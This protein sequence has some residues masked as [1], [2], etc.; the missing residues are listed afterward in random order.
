MSYDNLFWGGKNRAGVNVPSHTQW[1]I[2]A[3]SL[4][5]DC[6]IWTPTSDK[7][8][9][10][11]ALAEARDGRKWRYCEAGATGLSTTLL[12]QSSVPIAGWV[13][14][15]QT[16]SPGVPVATDKIVTVTMTTTATA[17]D[18]IDGYLVV[19]DATG[20]AN[21]YLI[22]DNKTG[23]ANATSG[24]DVSIEIADVGGIRTAWTTSSYIT[25]TKNKHKDVVVAPTSVTA[26]VVGVNLVAVTANYFFWAQVHGPCPMLVDSDGVVAGDGVQASQNSGGSASILD[27]GVTDVFIGY[28]LD[29]GASDADTCIIDLR[30][31]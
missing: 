20:E 27:G 21:M 11:G 13:D 12:N 19:T 6:D 1:K 5:S 10:L 9:P 22:K 3:E 7:R 26:V 18:F 16:D 28:G 30:I 15:I 25:V 2:K 31:E 8:F 24:Y 23:T 14:E 4:L 29:P 17:G